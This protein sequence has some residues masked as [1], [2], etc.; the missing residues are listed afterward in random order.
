MF[1]NFTLLTYESEMKSD[2]LE[3]CAQSLRLITRRQTLFLDSSIAL[4][5]DGHTYTLMSVS[6]KT[7]CFWIGKR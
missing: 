3:G 5:I 7:I 6:R 2:L 1:V 4:V